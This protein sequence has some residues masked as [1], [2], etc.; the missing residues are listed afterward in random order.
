MEATEIRIVRRDIELKVFNFKDV[1]LE[2]NLRWLIRGPN[3]DM[4]MVEIQPEE[5]PW[6]QHV[7]PWEHEIFI[8]EGKGEARSGDGGEPFEEGDVIYIPSDEPHAFVNKGETVLRFI[9][10]IPADVDLEQ[11]KPFNV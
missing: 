5:T 2:G 10:C 1:K 8:V 4:R 6:T 11:I 3:F 7:H 9:C